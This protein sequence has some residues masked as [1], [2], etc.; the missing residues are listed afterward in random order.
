[1]DLIYTRE[2]QRSNE[3]ARANKKQT[4]FW[5]MESL[6][7]NKYVAKLKYIYELIIWIWKCGM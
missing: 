3:C 6:T 1:M 5:K 2:K 4:Q 7:F